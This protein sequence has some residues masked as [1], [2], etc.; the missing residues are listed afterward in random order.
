MDA[1][2][3]TAARGSPEF[4]RIVRYHRKRAGLTQ[5]ELASLAGVGKTVVF[6]IENGKAT[7][8]LTTLRKVLTALNVK[9]DWASPLRRAYDESVAAS[10]G[11]QEPGNG[12]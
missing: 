1:T 4:A 3:P 9:L 7:V 12:E 2:Q 6:D 10:S 5:P 11:I 8:R